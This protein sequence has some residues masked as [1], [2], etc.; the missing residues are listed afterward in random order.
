MHLRIG[1]RQEGCR[2]VWLLLPPVRIGARKPDVSCA[3]LGSFFPWQGERR[4][5]GPE[6]SWSPLSHGFPSQARCGFGDPARAGPP[7]Q[8]SAVDHTFF[9]RPTKPAGRDRV[10]ASYGNL[11]LLNSSRMKYNTT[12]MADPTKASASHVRCLMVIG[13]PLLLYDADSPTG[14]S[15]KGFPE[16][17]ASPPRLRLP[18]R[19]SFRPAPGNFKLNLPQ[20]NPIYSI[21]MPDRRHPQ[22][23]RLA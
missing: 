23:E 19:P 13:I 7:L 16:A 21:T 6:G 1:T 4:A 22:F 15:P 12:N 5:L 9:I 14:G 2:A 10:P 20:F 3:G 11:A 8:H 17:V 18:K